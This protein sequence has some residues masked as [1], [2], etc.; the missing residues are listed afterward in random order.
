MFALLDPEAPGAGRLRSLALELERGVPVTRV[1]AR[2]Y[3]DRPQVAADIARGERCAVAL[4]R[5]Q[6]LSPAEGEL[7]LAFEES[8]RIE[9][10]LERIGLGRQDRHQALRKLAGRML[11]PLLVV[12]LAVPAF[13]IGFL[14]P[15]GAWRLE[16]FF[17]SL[18]VALALLNGGLFLLVRAGFR[19]WRRGRIERWPL[20]GPW[21]LDLEKEQALALLEAAHAA[22]LL[23]DE[24]FDR[25]ARALSSPTLRGRLESMRHAV[26]RCGEP[27][28]VIH[29]ALALP[30]YCHGFLQAGESAGELERGLAESRQALARNAQFSRDKMIKGTA[31]LL[32]FVQLL[33]VV[34]V[35]VHVFANYLA[36]FD[37][38]R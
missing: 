24:A 1:C 19:A 13:H 22:G 35:I 27:G 20:L 30:E 14:I 16:A 36:L 7:L 37:A 38:I 18:L 26:A 32:F 33:A 12:E 9:T 28:S 5:A 8:G 15:P 6:V 10:G 25:T 31:A 34:I 2:L 3:A 4:R 21:F 11:L 23:W 29:S 17:L